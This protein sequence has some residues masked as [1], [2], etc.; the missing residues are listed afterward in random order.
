[1][2]KMAA[3]EPRSLVGVLCLRGGRGG[4]YFAGVESLCHA[5]HRRA[6]RSHVLHGVAWLVPF[7]DQSRAE[8]VPKHICKP[9]NWVQH[10]VEHDC[11][12]GGSSAMTH[13]MVIRSYGNVERCIMAALV[14][15]G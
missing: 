5:V 15:D 3:A 12:A 11:A 6:E 1:M 7:R 8:P 10:D 2:C 4:P 9:T 14:L 13:Y